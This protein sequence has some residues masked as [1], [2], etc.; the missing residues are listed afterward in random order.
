MAFGTG[1]VHSA[2]ITGKRIGWTLVGIATLL[3]GGLVFL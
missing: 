1:G 3:I 2:T